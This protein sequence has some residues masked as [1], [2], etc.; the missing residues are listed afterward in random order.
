MSFLDNITTSVTGRTLTR[1]A[2]QTSD[3]TYSLQSGISNTLSNGI[4]TLG[5]SSS[6]AGAVGGAVGRVATGVLDEQIGK[7]LTNLIN[8]VGGPDPLLDRTEQLIVG[9]AAS[10]ITNAFNTTLDRTISSTSDVLKGGGSTVMSQFTKDPSPAAFLVRQA[11]NNVPGL[12]AS[13]PSDKK[14][15]IQNLTASMSGAA[16][17]CYDIAERAIA[18]NGMTISTATGA[19]GSIHKSMTKKMPLGAEHTTSGLGGQTGDRVSS[20]IKDQDIDALDSF[21][22]VS[23]SGLAFPE[24]VSD[25]KAYMGLHIEKYVRPTPTERSEIVTEPNIYLPLPEAIIDSTQL[26]HSEADVQEWGEL[27]KNQGGILNNVKDAIREGSQ[28]NFKAAFESLKDAAKGTSG[29]ATRLAMQKMVNM[30][31]SVAPELSGIVESAVGKVPNPHPTVFFK[32]L[33]LKTHTLQWK[34]SPNNAGESDTIKE[35]IKLM[36][37][38]FLPKASTALGMS[39][40]EYPSMVTPKI[41][42]GD[43]ES[44]TF[45]YNKSVVQ[46]INISYTPDGSSAFYN[47]GAPVAIIL[48]LELKEIEYH[49]S[50]KIK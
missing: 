17:V 6:T 47:T 50:D 15:S 12:S 35:I 19:A 31:Q 21:Y 33:N 37:Q 29:I 42:G 38:K 45:E 3:L 18:D 22:T 32:G 16:D 41:Y 39:I 26:R 24:N 1:V 10:L 44:Y 23:P 7:G 13:V 28:D 36:K 43:V 20:T 14:G 46:A 8:S 5:V 9:E 48:T 34:L 30:A 2:S 27:L 40:L 4:A 25:L 49:T 11:M